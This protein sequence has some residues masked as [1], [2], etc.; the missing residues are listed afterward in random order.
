MYT[1]SFF[2]IDP[3]DERT[4]ATQLGGMTLP[5]LTQFL[6][7]GEHGVIA[8]AGR[9]ADAALARGD[10]MLARGQHA[11]A[12]AAYEEGL[13]LGGK[14][15]PQRER[16]VGSDTWA[17]M[18]SGQSQVCAETAAKEAASMA[19]GQ[20]FGR[21]VLAG[22][23]CVNGGQQAPWAEAP[24]KTLRPLAEEAIALPATLRDHRF[25]LYQQLMHAA[26]MDGDKA[27]VARWGERWLDELEATRPANEDE[28]SALDI[29]RVD[30]AYFLG[31][32]S[33]V[34]PALIASERAMPTNYNASLRLAQMEIEAKQYDEA[35][36]AC[37]R[38]LV[39]VSGP[40]GR[41][42]LFET[43]ADALTQG[44]R[45]AEAR[46]V[47]EEALQSARSIGG[48]QARDRNLA[49]ISN[50]IKELPKDAK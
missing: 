12:A 35:I 4:S 37:D 49:R 13:R 36:A 48:K 33:R 10:E 28:R 42:W 30:A 46:R 18:L 29:A 23:M 21:V 38:G 50:T 47:L 31:A 11:G 22:L 16:A 6:D 41:T 17:L 43:K 1:P 15:W 19:R 2:V 34:L 9:P 39:H 5:E 45:P 32:A 24:R 25:Q 3:A 20:M 40:L 27:T 44:G 26:E 7:R 14:T 8:K